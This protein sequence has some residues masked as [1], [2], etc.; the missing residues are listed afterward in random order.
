[1]TSVLPD[2]S[3]QTSILSRFLVH[4]YPCLVPYAM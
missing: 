2:I 1:M 4:P 3:S